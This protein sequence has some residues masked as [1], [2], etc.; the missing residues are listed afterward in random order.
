[1][2]REEVR[3]LII[4]VMSDS[5]KLTSVV[6]TLT[7]LINKETP[8][9]FSDC[10]THNEPAE[11]NGDCDCDEPITEDLLELL[12]FKFDEYPTGEWC[13][14]YDNIVHD[15]LKGNFTIL[16][17][18]KFKVGSSVSVKTKRDIINFR[19]KSNSDQPT[20]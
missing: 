9:H 1:M 3:D 18:K 8:I 5:D 4:S 14:D 2:K 6:D 12:G 10:A 11:R 7:E 17:E 13:D 19:M 15:D 16:N 20:K